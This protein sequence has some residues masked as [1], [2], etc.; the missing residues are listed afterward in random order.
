MLVDAH[1][2]L[3]SD[4]L[5]AGADDLI[6]E[7][8]QAGVGAIVMA[9]VDAASVQGQAELEARHPGV[10]FRVLGLHPQV[11]PTLSDAGIDAELKAL[12]AAL[13]AARPVALGET[14]LDALT[15]ETRAD[16]PRQRRVFRAQL[17]LA[18]TLDL[19]VV[20]HLLRADADALAILRAD[21][22]PRAGGLVHAF[23]GSAEFARALSRLGLHISFCGTL[24]LPTS[25]RLREAARMLPDEQL[26][27]E[28]DSPDQTPFPA[29]PV[30][31]DGRRRAVP[32]RP[33]YLPHVVK[34]LA[35]VR[36]VA[37]D[38]A[39]RITSEN[40]RRLFG[41]PASAALVPAG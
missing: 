20:L 1:C 19:P 27:V 2:H 39:A 25:R 3:D 6:T 33:A 21:G 28:T 4:R 18:R 36:G 41:L 34:A 37:F 24:T 9:G 15:P 14:G 38:E 32:N 10:V 13:T 12:E 8:R 30:D 22:L 17:G 31:A 29:R 16:L 7:A 40:A 26:L 5:D 35:D 23:S 11:I